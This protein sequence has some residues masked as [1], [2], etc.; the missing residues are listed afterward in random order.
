[1][2]TPSVFLCHRQE[3]C[4]ARS[5][6][7]SLPN[8][9]VRYAEINRDSGTVVSGYTVT[10]VLVVGKLDGYQHSAEGSH[11][12]KALSEVVDPRAKRKDCYQCLPVD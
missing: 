12:Q 11:F 7:S 3:Q 5:C 6:W 4:Q 2:M 1:M 10:L 8:H 9:N